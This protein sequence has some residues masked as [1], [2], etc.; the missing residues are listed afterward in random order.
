MK[1]YLHTTASAL[2]G[3]LVK[4]EDFTH[5][6]PESLERIV[7]NTGIVSRY[8]SGPGEATSD[9][10]IRAAR[11]CLDR[12]G[13][14]A[15]SL[16]AV[17]L[18]TCTPDRLIPATAGKVSCAI[19]AGR[20][21]AFDINS[22]CSGSV[23]VLEV[24]RGLIAS[25]AARH[26]LAI[27]ADTCSKF[28]NR[29]DFATFPYF[30]DGAAAALLSAEEGLW[31]L[32]GSVLH[33]DG[34]G[35]E[36]VTMKAGGS[37]IPWANVKEE[38]DR[39]VTMDGRQVFAFANSKGAEVLEEVLAKCSIGK[40]EVSMFIVHQ[41][42]IN[43]I[44]QIAKK[45]GVE[46]GRFH[47]NVQRLGNTAGAS[48]LIATDEYLAGAGALPPGS[49]IVLAAFGAGLSWGGIALRRR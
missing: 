37:E 24:A 44:G 42:N 41:A 31:E 3:N 15:E 32:L 25:G 27:A 14:P 36:T 46:A 45:L 4:N 43:I 33:T 23:Y 48:V 38:G 17:V 2:P 26:V 16:D 20:A 47:T 12:I 8:R 49:N 10:A 9:L 39:Y 1:I 5:F 40:E 29:E 6:P 21:Y 30:G 28:L 34:R 11:A 22:A 7:K 19:G 18:A 13:F 35:Y